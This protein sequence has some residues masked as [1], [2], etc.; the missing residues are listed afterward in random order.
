MP[1]EMTYLGQVISHRRT[2]RWSFG[3]HPCRRSTWLDGKRLLEIL[4]GKRLVFVGD[5]LNQNMW[6]SLGCICLASLEHKDHAFEV[7]SWHEYIRKKSFRA[8]H[9]FDYNCSITSIE[10]H[11]QQ[12]ERFVRLDL[13][14]E[15][16]KYYKTADIIVFNSGHWSTDANTN[17]GQDFFVEADHIY[18]HLGQ[19]DAFVQALQKWWLTLPLMPL[20]LNFS[21]SDTVL[22]TIWVATKTP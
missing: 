6:A 10:Y 3:G 18:S 16:A 17:R 19:T 12:V 9:F 21:F 1:P 13:I 2:C 15:A 11:L 20:G 5:S 14:S 22:H 8:V 7:P 4:N